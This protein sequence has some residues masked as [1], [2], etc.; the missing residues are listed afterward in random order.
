MAAQRT[1]IRVNAAGRGGWIWAQFA[2][3]PDVNIYARV[4]PQGDRLAVVDI[5]LE[6]VG[7]GAISASTFRT[8]PI[9]RLEQLLNQPDLRNRLMERIDDDAGAAAVDVDKFFAELVAADPTGFL[10]RPPKALLRL[11]GINAARKPDEFYERVAE[12]Y[13]WVASFDEQPAAAL[14]DA[15]NVPVAIAY[16]WIKEARRRKLLAPGRRGTTDA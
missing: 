15:N 10:D 14:A 13:T 16:R 9:G 12:L 8:L 1:R 6:A 2:E 11:R 4:S 7:E 3:L 5:R